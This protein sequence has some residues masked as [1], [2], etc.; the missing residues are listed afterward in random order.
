[1]KRNP[2]LPSR[3]IL[4]S[5]GTALLIGVTF[6]GFAFW[7]M[8][9]DQHFRPFDPQM[10]KASS[11]GR[12]PERRS[13]ML[14]DLENRYLH[15][16]LNKAQVLNLLGEP[17][18]RDMPEYFGSDPWLKHASIIWSYDIGLQSVFG[19]DNDFFAIAFT[20]DGRVLTAWTWTS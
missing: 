13:P 7:R 2:I 11:S 6:V 5:C 14:H 3:W 8:F 20:E 17:D 15:R 16:G 9:E 1:M 4:L 12:S 19:I 10:W 18:R